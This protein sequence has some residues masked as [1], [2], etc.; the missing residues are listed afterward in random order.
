MFRAK[1]VYNFP[2]IRFDLDW[3]VFEATLNR[4]DQMN[5]HNSPWC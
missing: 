1:V 5:F 3:T 4:C 2:N